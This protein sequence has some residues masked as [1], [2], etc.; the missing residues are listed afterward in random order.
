MTCGRN[1]WNP[2]LPNII[3]KYKYR[4]VNTNTQ[5]QTHKYFNFL[6]F[7]CLLVYFSFRWE[8][9]VIADIPECP[10]ITE[11]SSLYHEI[12]IILNLND[13]NQIIDK[14][15]TNSEI[16]KWKLICRSKKS[17]WNAVEKD[18]KFPICPQQL[19]FTL[20]ARALNVPKVHF[21]KEPQL[22]S[23][24]SFKRVERKIKYPAKVWIMFS[25]AI[26]CMRPRS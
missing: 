3:H 17:K 14:K 11:G 13:T 25:L 4:Y 8:E 1:C 12:S 18:L 6:F 24:N 20:S 10:T 19:G 22:L 15:T 26:C 5:I 2:I 16:I 21:N 23:H 7:L 9:S